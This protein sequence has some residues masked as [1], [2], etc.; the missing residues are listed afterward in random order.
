MSEDCGEEEEEGRS[1]RGHGDGGRSSFLPGL[2]LQ[3][4]FY[5]SNCNPCN[6]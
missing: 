2:Q 3:P 4:P 1:T 5:P 6:L